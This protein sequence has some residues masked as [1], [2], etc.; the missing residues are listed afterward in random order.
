MK[1]RICLLLAVKQY[2]KAISMNFY[3][4]LMTI[5]QKLINILRNQYL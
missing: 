1:Y 5:L 3:T 4:V 2:G